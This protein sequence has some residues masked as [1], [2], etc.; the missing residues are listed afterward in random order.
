VAIGNLP[1][2]ATVNIA[3]SARNATGESQP[4][5]PVSAVVP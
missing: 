3:V 4:T 2:G 5:A 1:A